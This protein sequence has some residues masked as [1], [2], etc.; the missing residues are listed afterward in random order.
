M[1]L[2][3]E[4]HLA[5]P[6]INPTSSAACCRRVATGQAN[7]ASQ[8]RPGVPAARS[9]PTSLVPWVTGRY[10]SMRP[11][12]SLIPSCRDRG[13]VS[14]SPRETLDRRGS[15]RAKRGLRM[16]T[17]AMG[18]GGH[19]LAVGGVRWRWPVR[20]CLRPRR[21]RRAG[22]GRGAAGPRRHAGHVGWGLG[23]RVHGD[24]AGVRPAV[25]RTAGPGAEPEVGAAARHRHRPFRRREQ[26]AGD[27]LRGAAAACPAG[28][29]VGCGPQ[30]C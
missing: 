24:R 7:D 25:R 17:V 14:G 16:T 13:L 11:G 27:R 12:E 23:S 8:S 30:P 28:V 4:P 29:S 18:A 26:L 22:A 6:A 20:N 1:R 15:V 10:Y 9:G 3:G 19:A 21:H 5:R 2:L